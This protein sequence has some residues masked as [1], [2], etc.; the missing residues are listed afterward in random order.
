MAEA[1]PLNLTVESYGSADWRVAQNNDEINELLDVA[2]DRGL[3]ESSAQIA[4]A[5][6]S[7]E[8]RV[9]TDDARMKVELDEYFNLNNALRDQQLGDVPLGIQKKVRILYL[10]EN[11]LKLEDD[12]IGESGLP[13]EGLHDTGGENFV[14]V[15]RKSIGT[16]KSMVIGALSGVLAHER[17]ML[18]THAAIVVSPNGA[19]VGFSGRGNTGKTTSLL[20]TYERLVDKGFRIITDDWSMIDEH[21]ATVHPVDFLVSVRPESLEGLRSVYS[22]GWIEDLTKRVIT[23]EKE[24]SKSKPA[25]IAEVYGADMV[26]ES[27]VLRG[28]IFTSLKK[29]FLDTEERT[30]IPVNFKSVSDTKLLAHRLRDDAY[31][32][33]EIGSGAG[34]PLLRRYEALIDGMKCALVYTRAGDSHRKAQAN[35]MAEWVIEG[36]T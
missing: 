4:I 14:A 5:G 12:T 16:F 32:A 15:G 3:F 29:L 8:A 21:D 31:H 34:K 25:G 28:I 24:K 2:M 17:H 1:I 27:G 9:L 33:P 30:H 19:C 10:T 36:A 22:S 23:F 20:S 18:P 7:V 11:G 13:Y 6:T 26:G 35:Q